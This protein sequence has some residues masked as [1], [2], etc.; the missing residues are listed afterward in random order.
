MPWWWDHIDALDIWYVDSWMVM[1]ML[2]CLSSFEAK[3]YLLVLDAIKMFATSRC[4]KQ[5][6]LERN[7]SS[8]VWVVDMVRR[9]EFLYRTTWLLS[10]YQLHSNG[11]SFSANFWPAIIGAAS[12]T[13][14][15]ISSIGLNTLVILFL[16]V[17]CYVHHHNT[18]TVPAIVH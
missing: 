3:S 14:I 2:L 1:V 17:V 18:H 7:Q 13:M 16:L 6:T 15:V 8:F 12:S 5:Q 11:S 9:E 4:I 10:L